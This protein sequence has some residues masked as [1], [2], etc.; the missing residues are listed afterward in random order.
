MIKSILVAVLAIG[1]IQAMP[2]GKLK[3][4]IGKFL[5]LKI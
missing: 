2:T 1:V 4:Y 3:F 5:I